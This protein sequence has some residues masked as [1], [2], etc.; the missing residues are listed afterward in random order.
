MFFFVLFQ[1]VNNFATLLVVIVAIEDIL[2][3]FLESLQ[4]WVGEGLLVH[5]KNLESKN[6]LESIFSDSKSII[7]SHYNLCLLSRNSQCLL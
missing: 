3:V 2:A 1:G 5:S 7:E 4:L 6:R